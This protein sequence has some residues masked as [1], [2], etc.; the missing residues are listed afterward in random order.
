MFSLNKVVISYTEILVCTMRYELY[1]KYF[2]QLLLFYD[3]LFYLVLLKYCTNVTL[4]VKIAQHFKSIVQLLLL[5][6]L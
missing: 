6:V 3:K 5:Q 1:N 4:I 2:K